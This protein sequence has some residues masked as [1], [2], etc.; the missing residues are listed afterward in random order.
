MIKETLALA[1]KHAALLSGEVLDVGSFN[2]NG[3]LRDV[4]AVTLGV[5]TRPGPGVDLVLDAA[6]LPS[7]GREFDAVVSSDSLEHMEHWQ[8]AL[9]GM[10]SVLKPGGYMLLTTVNLRKGRHDH[11]NDFWR[12]D[13]WALSSI[14][15]GNLVVEQS[16]LDAYE[17]I[18]VRKDTEALDLTVK[19]NS[20]DEVKRCA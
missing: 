3:Q 7:L 10:W 9:A 17:A 6:D 1:A 12:F 14:F 5:D 16:T 11:P 2:V 8:A 19:V 20:V 4:V 15:A 13:A 18:L